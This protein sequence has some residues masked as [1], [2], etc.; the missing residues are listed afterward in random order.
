MKALRALIAENEDWLVGRVLGYAERHG[1]TRFSS[2]L[3]QPWR[4]SIS[5]RSSPWR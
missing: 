4:E 3:A 1:Y 5:S 2:T